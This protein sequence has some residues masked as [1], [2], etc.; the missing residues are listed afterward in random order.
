M[1]RQPASRL[2]TPLTHWL[3]APHTIPQVPQLLTSLCTSTHTSEHRSGAFA[4]L[5][6]P[7]V[8]TEYR[9]DCHTFLDQTCVKAGLP[10]GAWRKGDARIERFSAEVFAE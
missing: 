2:Q 7:Q 9:W 6:L 4:G 5:L 1:R 3:P 10:R 8:A